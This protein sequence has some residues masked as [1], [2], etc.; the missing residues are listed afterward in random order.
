[1]KQKHLFITAILSFTFFLSNS[2]SQTSNEELDKKWSRIKIDEKLITPSTSDYKYIPNPYSQRYKYGQTEAIVSPNYRIKPT[3]NTTQSELSIDIHPTNSNIF[4]AGSNSTGW[5][6]SSATTLYGTG[7]FWSTNSGLN[8]LGSDTT[9]KYFGSSNSGDPAAVISPNGNFYM[10]YIRNGGGQ[11]VSVSTNNGVSWN[12]YIAGN[13][14]SS[15]LDLLDKNHLWVDKKVGSPYQNRVYAA[16]THFVSSSPSNNQVVLSYSTNNGVNWSSFVDLSSSL[17]PGSHAQGVNI[18]T[19]PNGEVYATFAIYDNWGSGVY[20]EDAIGFAKSTDGGVTWTKSRIYSAANFGIRGNLKPTSIRVSSFP[21]MSVDR[22][23]GPYNGYIYIVWPQRGVSPAG[24]DPDIVM[25]KS[26]NGGNTW[27]SPIR[28]NDDAINNGKDQY[29]PWCAV[30]QTTGRLNIVFYDNRHT[31]NDSTGVWMAT[32]NNG[33]LSF[34]NFKVSDANF[35]PKPINGLASGYQGDYIGIS[36][37]NDKAY[38]FWSEDRTG[39]YQAWIAE[40][41]FTTFPLNAFNLISPIDNVTLTSFPSSNNTYNFN[42]DT[43]SLTASYKWIFG[44]P[45]TNSPLLTLTSPTNSLVLTSGQLDNLLASLGLLPGDSLVGQWDVWAYRNNAPDFDSLKSS[46]GSRSITL[47]RGIPQLL[48]YSLSSPVDNSKII[49]TVFNNNPISFLWRKSGEGVTY[50]WK[51][52]QNV[53]TNPLLIYSSNN[54]GFDTTFSINNSTL[55]LILG[56]NGLSPGDSIIG[57]WAVWA[58]NGLDSLKSTQTYNLIIKRQ[59]KGDILIAYDSTSANGRTSRDS[60][61]AYLN[62]K[63]LTFDLFNKGGQTSTNNMTFRGYNTIIWL[64][65][66]TSVMSTVQKDSIKAYL[67]NPAP[68]QKSKLIIFSE[69]IGYQFGRSGSTYYDINFM[70][71]YLGANYVSDRPTS[72]GNQGLVGVYINTGLTDSTVGTWPDVLSRF[73]P[74]TTHDLYKF[75]SS[76]TMNAIGK[77]AATYNVATFGVDIRSLRRA[78]D[79]QLGSPVPRILDAALLYVNTNGTLQREYELNI[80]C[81]IEGLYDGEKMK[82]DTVKVELRN[83]ISPYS[84]V[85]DKNIVLDSAGRG[86]ATYTSISEGINYY[87]VI[88]HRNALETWS[89][90]P[91]QFIGGVLNYDFTTDSAKAFGENMKLINDKWCLFMGD[92]NNDGAINILDDFEVYNSSYLNT[93]SL[94]HD[95]NLDGNIDIYDDL[96]VYNNSFLGIARL[97][98]ERSLNTFPSKQQTTD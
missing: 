71:Q 30:D 13:D 52:G 91:Q 85:E 87:M 8:W 53:T 47:K 41:I 26:T 25:I 4:F 60:V 29:Y 17:S 57:Q 70:N 12:S 56:D 63:N 6:G 64:G 88:K 5:S 19:G 40:V 78:S 75:R 69:D 39:N 48:N 32:S 72:G 89:Q 86:S 83:A 7:V 49:T 73:D 1:M 82:S 58:F 27:S 34:D 10:G 43:S 92:I 18:N 46:N 9:S 35:K 38:P 55:D 2:Y 14:P 95:T 33:G 93:Y 23:G 11:G 66:G 62:S 42:W 59:A 97:I 65:Q 22:S 61:M 15:S 50:K 44:S 20:G 24:S 3:S 54:D 79:S 84:L 74:S 28:I 21:S 37:V 31:S 16:W 90:S 77:I 98:P 51:F 94:V 45:S 80:T 81:L 68:G 96:I 67:N 36:A 76:N